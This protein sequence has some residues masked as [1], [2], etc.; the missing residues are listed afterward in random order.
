MNNAMILFAFIFLSAIAFVAIR[1]R[2]H[3]KAKIL[4]VF[5]ISL[6]PSE[7]RPKPR[8]AKRKR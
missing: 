6:A 7:D 8:K 4:A 3:L 1:N 2:Y 5:E